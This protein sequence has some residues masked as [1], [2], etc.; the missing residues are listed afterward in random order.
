MS[1]EPAENVTAKIR[2]Q[3]G[4]GS[5]TFDAEAGRIVN[6]RNNQKNGN[7]H[8]RSRPGYR[9][10]DRDDHDDDARAVALTIGQGWPKKA[11]CH[12]PLRRSP[13][14]SSTSDECRVS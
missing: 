5:L 13:A 4:K 9:P 1:L 3:E 14:V 8:L 11:I 10:I 6:S 2:M 7:D 12:K